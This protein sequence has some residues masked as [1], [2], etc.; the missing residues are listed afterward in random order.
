[1]SPNDFPPEIEPGSRIATRDARIA[2]REAQPLRRFSRALGNLLPLIVLAISMVGALTTYFRHEVAGTLGGDIGIAACFV[3]V[4]LVF[5]YL[6][7]TVQHF[8]QVKK[9]PR[10]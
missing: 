1:M 6:S 9:I 3:I 2:R 5:T 7:P 10:E 4:L 8:V